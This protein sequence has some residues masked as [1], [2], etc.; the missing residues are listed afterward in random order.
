MGTRGEEDQKRESFGCAERSP[1][2]REVVGRGAQ[3]LK[4]GVECNYRGRIVR[5]PF[6]QETTPV[7]GWKDV[8][9]MTRKGL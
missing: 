2:D 5:N 7:E 6:G 4:E 9:R 1:G 8:V 3:M